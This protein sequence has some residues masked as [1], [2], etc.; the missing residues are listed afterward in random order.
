VHSAE[1]NRLDS[2]GGRNTSS[3]ALNLS[4]EIS[5]PSFVGEI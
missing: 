1:S 5:N 2:I 3:E 4:E